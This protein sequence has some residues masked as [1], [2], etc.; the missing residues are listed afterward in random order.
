MFPGRSEKCSPVKRIAAFVLLLVIAASGCL[1][2]PEATPDYGVENPDRLV[3]SIEPGK[4]T[5]RELLKRFGPPVT[6]AAQGE[7]TVIP[8]VY[9]H[10]YM[11]PGNSYAIR[12]DAWFE[13]FSTGRDLTEYHRVYYYYALS[14]S[15]VLMFFW[16]LDYRGSSTETDRLWFL[17]DERTGTVE[18]YAFKKHGQPLLFGLKGAAPPREKAPAGSGP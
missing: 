7:M 12:S 16:L 17:V 5:K 13:L 6:I 11:R 18:D 14:R 4:T 15:R 8:L 3:A 2:L 10:A 9:D 1:I